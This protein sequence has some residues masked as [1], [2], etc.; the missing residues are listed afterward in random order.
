[1]QDIVSHGAGCFCRLNAPIQDVEH[2]VRAGQAVLWDSGEEH[3][4]HSANGLQALIV[5][6]D[7]LGAGSR[8]STSESA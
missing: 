2:T 6:A 3:A 1:M 8:G 7:A 4:V 5:K